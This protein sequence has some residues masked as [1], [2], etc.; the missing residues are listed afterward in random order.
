MNITFS[1][2]QQSLEELC[3]LW[4]I[5]EFSVFGSVLGDYFRPES[6]IDCLIEFSQE[7]QWDLFDIIELKRQLSD[8]FNREVDLVEKNSISNPFILKSIE[9]N[10]QVLYSSHG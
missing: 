4:L 1:Q 9:E 3:N 2:Y 10:H 7:A 8:L 5:S 6:D